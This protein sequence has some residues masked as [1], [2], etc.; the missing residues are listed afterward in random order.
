MATL[1]RIA[2]AFV[3][4]AHRVVWATGATVDA[5]G[6]PWTRVLHPL[7]TWDGETLT[8][9]V[10]TSPLSPKRAHLDAHPYISFT[11]WHPNHD[12]C[13]A[14]CH[15]AWDLSDEGRRAGW[16]ALAT[17]PAPV[18]YDPAI[19]PGWDEPT[20]PSFGI[21]RLRPWRLHVMPGAV[22]LSGSGEVLRWQDTDTASGTEVG[23]TARTE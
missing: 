5:Q 22:M 4:M 8:G 3:A 10:A 13:T 7:W 23:P 19:I 18:G 15:A 21:L 6:R 20:S 2:P 16:E 12:T 17:A 11:Y 9:I 14:Q 1:E